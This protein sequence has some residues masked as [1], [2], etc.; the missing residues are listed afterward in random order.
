MAAR[1][2]ESGAVDADAAV[3]AEVEIGAVSRSLGWGATVG[4]CACCLRRSRRRTCPAVVASPVI[5]LHVALTI[6]PPDLPDGRDTQYH[7][8]VTVE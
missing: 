2:G 8:S 7:K 6:R 4:V 3:T 1:R 5:L